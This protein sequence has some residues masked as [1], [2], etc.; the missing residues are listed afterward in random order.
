MIALF[1]V[2]VARSVENLCKTG[3]RPVDALSAANYFRQDW[4]QNGAIAPSECSFA[5][6]FACA[7]RRGR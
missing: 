4:A 1:C 2:I 7:P 3:G 6:G 5:L